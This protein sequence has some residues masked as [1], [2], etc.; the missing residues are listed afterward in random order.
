MPDKD[1]R[2]GSSLLSISQCAQRKKVSRQAIHDAIKRGA[3]PAIRIGNGY[4]IQVTDCDAYVPA[5][6]PAERGHRSAG[7]PKTKRTTP[8]EAVDHSFS[9]DT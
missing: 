3:L 7:K 6:T 4:A 9:E 5:L 8:T 2:M 1:E